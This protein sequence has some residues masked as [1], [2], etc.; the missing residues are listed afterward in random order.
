M[1]FNLDVLEVIITDHV[2]LNLYAF[3]DSWID[4]LILEFRIGSR[5]EDRSEDS[6]SD[7]PVS[8][9]QLNQVLLKLRRIHLKCQDTG[10]I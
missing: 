4:K 10:K 1:T 8:T 6:D 9:D 2:K 3:K 5:K 7:E